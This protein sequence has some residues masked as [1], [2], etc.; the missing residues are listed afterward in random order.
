VWTVTG[1]SA[2]GNITGSQLDSSGTTIDTS[3]LSFTGVIS[4]SSVTLKLG[5]G[6]RSVS[7]TVT[8]GQL[9]IELPESDGTIQSVDF[10]PGTAGAFNSDVAKIQAVA[11]T[12]PQ[13]LL[14]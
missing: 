3:T 7:G 12:L 13:G 4:G 8:S 11:K 2:H 1:D 9:Q 5:G 6:T 10:V 14:K